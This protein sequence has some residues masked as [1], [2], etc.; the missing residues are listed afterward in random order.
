MLK[1]IILQVFLLIFIFTICVI[2]FKTYFKKE[3]RIEKIQTK[4]NEAN[5]IKDESNE[6]KGNLIYDVVYKSNNESGNNYVILSKISELPKK[7][8]DLV[9]MKGVEATINIKNNSPIK[10]FSDKAVFNKA[11]YDTDFSDNVL[12]IYDD[13]Y[14]TSNNLDLFFQKNLA[15]ISNEIIYK[16]LNTTLQADMIEI[17]MLSK[18]SKIFMKDKKRKIKISTSD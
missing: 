5:K 1:K 9:L 12:I 4:E 14:I 2:F 7:D 18:K 8:S 6:S 13:H 16:N 3:D 11:T 17:N 15:I 10:I